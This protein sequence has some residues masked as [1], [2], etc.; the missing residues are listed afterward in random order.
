MSDS[1]RLL[2]FPTDGIGS[3]GM[4]LRDYFA[5]QAIA[6]NCGYPSDQSPA[7]NVLAEEA[8]KIADAMMEAR[9]E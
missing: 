3:L 1:N 9:E 6:S 4:E 7:F 5:G 2:A 8:Y